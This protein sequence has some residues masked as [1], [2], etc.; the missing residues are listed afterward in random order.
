MRMESR[1]KKSQIQQLS[2]V[3]IFEIRFKGVCRRPR[4]ARC[5]LR[6]TTGGPASEYD[7]GIYLRRKNLKNR[8]IKQILK[9]IPRIEAEFKTDF[10]IIFLFF[11]LVGKS[12]KSSFS[13]SELINIKKKEKKNKSHRPK[14][15]P[16][17]SSTSSANVKSAINIS[18]GTPWRTGT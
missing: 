1:Y 3:E 9:L 12:P 4:R 5:V 11:Y 16:L 17:S 6:C 13:L 7:L 18:R 2:F 8:I 15:S 10:S 14:I